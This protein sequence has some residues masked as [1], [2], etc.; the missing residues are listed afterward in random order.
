MIP[1]WYKLNKILMQA[2][3]LTFDYDVSPTKDALVLPDARTKPDVDDPISKRILVW[4]TFRAL[5]VDVTHSHDIRLSEFR[6]ID[7]NIS[8][9][10]NDI[11]AGTVTFRAASAGLRLHTAQAEARGTQVKSTGVSQ[12]GT[13]LID[14][15]APGDNFS[16]LIPYSLEM[17]LTAISLRVEIAYSTV[18]GQFMY[19]TKSTIPVILPLAVNVQDTFKENVLYSLFTIRPST[20]SPIRIIDTYIEKSNSFEATTA[21]SCK[22]ET[23]VFSGQPFSVIAQ[24]RRKAGS[25]ASEDSKQ[26]DRRL[27]LTIEYHCLDRMVCAIIEAEMLQALAATHME[28]FSRLLLQHLRSHLRSTLTPNDFENFALLDEFALGA[29]EQYNWDEILHALPINDAAVLRDILREWH[30]VSKVKLEYRRDS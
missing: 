7:V 4:R 16:I 14:R 21:P 25:R 2:G 23:G 6:S 30:L 24:V 27:H 5:A 1:G 17:D 13:V 3:G 20:S 15:I 26:V 19:A 22:T 8:S 28:R 29:F 11:V 12:P 9:G 18:K 10:W